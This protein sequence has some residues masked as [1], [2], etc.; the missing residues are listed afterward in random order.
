MSDF[1]TALALVAVIE[2]LVL[3]LAPLRYQDLLQTLSE[4]PLT[5]K[6]TIGLIIVAFGVVMLWAVRAFVA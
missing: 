2:G 6:R 1:L 3:A 5:R 4:M